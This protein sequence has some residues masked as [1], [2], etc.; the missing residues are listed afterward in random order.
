L[1]RK[2]LGFVGFEEEKES[3]GEFKVPKF[4]VGQIAGHPN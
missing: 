2:G 3:E 4:D 1:R